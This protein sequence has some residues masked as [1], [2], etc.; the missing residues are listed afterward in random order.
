[1]KKV[2]N[3]R[4]ELWLR[5]GYPPFPRPCMKP[6]DAIW[7]NYY[8]MRHEFTLFFSWLLRQ[9]LS[10]ELHMELLDLVHKMIMDGNLKFAQLLRN[11]LVEKVVPIAGILCSAFILRWQLLKPCNLTV[12]STDNWYCPHHTTWHCIQNNSA[13]SRGLLTNWE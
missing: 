4:G 5:G 8:C 6:W 1:M 12:E 13:V 10:K 3:F 11:A 2:G 9:P 7:Y